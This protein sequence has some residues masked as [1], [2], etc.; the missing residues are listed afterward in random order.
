MEELNFPNFEN[1]NF[2]NEN[3]N[4]ESKEKTSQEKKEELVIFELTWKWITYK[5]LKIKIK[6]IEEKK[7]DYKIFE[8]EEILKQ[9]KKLEKE[10][11]NKAFI[12]KV[13]EWDNLWKLCYKYYGKWSIS[14]KILIPKLWYKENIKVWEKLPLPLKKFLLP[15]L[16]ENDNLDW[17]K[18]WIGT[19]DK[20]NRDWFRTR[21]TGLGQ[22]LQ[23]DKQQNKEQ[24][25]NKQE[26][27]NNKQENES[28][29]NNQEQ[30]KQAEENKDFENIDI[31]EVDEKELK[32][33]DKKT[34]KEIFEK[35]NLK[36]VKIWLS[37]YADYLVNYANNLEFI[38]ITWRRKLQ[39]NYL[40]V[41][42]ILKEEIKNI[43][44]SEDLEKIYNENKKYF[45][46]NLIF[47]N[48]YFWNK[49]ILNQF[50]S[51]INV[52]KKAL[53]EKLEIN[54]EKI[55]KDEIKEKTINIKWEIFDTVRKIDETDDGIIIKDSWYYEANFH[56]QTLN[57]I[58]T[59]TNLLSWKELENIAKIKDIDKNINFSLMLE[60]FINN[61]EIE[62]YDNLTETELIQKNMY[63][64]R[65]KQIIDNF[66]I[67]EESKKE[68]LEKSIS[69]FEKNFAKWYEEDVKKVAKIKYNKLYLKDIKRIWKIYRETLRKYWYY[70]DII[71]WEIKKDEMS[72][73]LYRKNKPIKEV[74][75]EIKNKVSKYKLPSFKEYYEN[76][77][78][79][80]EKWVIENYK[81]FLSEQLTNYYLSK[82][83]DKLEELWKKDKLVKM[84]EKIQWIWEYKMSDETETKIK[85]RWKELAIQTLMLTSSIELWNIPVKMLLKWME[86]TAK[87][88]LA[89]YAIS[90]LAFTQIYN[91]ED[92]E[93]K[94]HIE[95]KK[96]FLEKYFES[97]KDR[98]SLG[99]NFILL[100]WM[101]YLKEMGVVDKVE[102]LTIDKIGQKFGNKYNK[103]WEMIWKINGT[104]TE[105]VSAISL[106]EWWTLLFDQ[107]NITKEDILF[108]IALIL[109]LKVNDRIREKIKKLNINWKKMLYIQ[110]EANKIRKENIKKLE[111]K[112]KDEKGIEEM[113]KD[114]GK[115]YKKMD[116]KDVKEKK[117]VKTKINEY[118]D[119]NL[120][121][122]W[123][124]LTKEDKNLKNKIIKEIEKILEKR[125]QKFIEEWWNNGY[126]GEIAEI[127]LKKLFERT[128]NKIVWKIIEHLEWKWVN[129]LE[130]KV[131]KKVENT[132][133]E[134]LEKNKTKLEKEYSIWRLD[135]ERTVKYMMRKYKSF[136]E[137]TEKLNKK[138]K[139][140]KIKLKDERI[141]KIID[142]IYK[143]IEQK[144]AILYVIDYYKQL[145]ERGKDKRK[146]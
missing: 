130:E 43:R 124:K 107:K 14:I 140:E 141:N 69:F 13:K 108:A 88:R 121:I 100:W 53:N 62:N 116:W 77:L 79:W 84:Y 91:I 119:K 19:D 71:S 113:L 115:R 126:G 131:L 31:E 105:T 15:L 110:E 51:V 38:D 44:T 94:N 7:K 46:N 114:F 96:T 59:E 109:S 120:W 123:E 2:E 146:D 70:Q 129:L 127:W 102:K 36:S 58:L 73:F 57:H 66:D 4:Q 137:T 68:L 133:R 55:D 144:E 128:W 42:K 50:K 20:K 35:E 18:D 5:T 21:I 80:Y 136:A 61:K 98:K 142:K 17:L 81:L 16:K 52:C 85:F 45:D 1:D 83:E 78:K 132:I 89:D 93:R 63:K 22:N 64:E 24:G 12:V 29:E 125:Y 139:E 82:K 134:Y 101:K 33:V 40:K 90:S 95:D 60:W 65:L 74:L 9:I 41:A 138:M 143:N 92:I 3:K 30:T 23:D 47:D 39:E 76:S 6:E 67:D 86:R 135:I 97:V 117:Y 10:F 25:D 34:A 54:T 11:N 27:K 37:I 112:L 103:L 87:I 49:R 99:K 122:K 32:Q 75:D 145:R 8:D 56:N 104:V 28:Q 111:E 118:V 106:M 48:K 26:N 72:K